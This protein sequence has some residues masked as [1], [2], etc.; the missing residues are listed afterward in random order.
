VGSAT[1]AA[2]L[3]H[4]RSGRTRRRHLRPCVHRRTVADI[5]LRDPRAAL[6]GRSSLEARTMLSPCHRRS[7][8][9]VTVHAGHATMFDAADASDLT[10]A[11]FRPTSAAQLGTAA[12]FDRRPRF[13]A[14]APFTNASAVSAFDSRPRFGTA[15]A[16]FRHGSAIMSYAR[17]RD[18]VGS[19]HRDACM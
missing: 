1:T 17:P 10:A 15:A 13:S 14:A 2:A 8:P 16:P 6:H 4:C 5:R 7:V 3:W 9:E 12:G 11:H 19:T 18:P